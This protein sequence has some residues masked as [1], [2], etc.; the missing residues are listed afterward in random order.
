MRL[1]T[2]QANAFKCIFDVLKDIVNDVNFIFDTDG[3]KISILD[4]SKVTFIN[5]HLI[6]ENFEVY[7]CSH[8]FVA[9]LN[10]SNT[11]KLLKTIGNSDI[12]EISIDEARCECMD[13]IIENSEKKSKTT[14][15]MKLLDINEENYNMNGIV[16]QCVTD[17]SSV[18]FQRIIRDMSNFSN[19][20]T[21][22]RSS[23]T[24]K[25]KCTGDFVDQETVIQCDDTIDQVYENTYSIKYI[26]I[27]TKSTN[28][29]STV[30]IQNHSDG[31][32]SFKYQ[33][34]NL[35]DIYFY[36]APNTDL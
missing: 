29:S 35:G 3:V 24:I 8:Q 13:I 12:L 31:P 25:F 26:S 28:L 9:G 15:Q 4:T 30:S 20:V 33:I 36:L 2:I 10:I 14:F 27:F 19:L 22:L 16:S 23:N 1:K 18:H 11:F 5:M 6:A 7:E 34:A 21:I 17:I 32:I